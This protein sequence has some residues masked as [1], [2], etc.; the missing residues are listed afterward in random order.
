MTSN[1]V[2]QGVTAILASPISDSNLTS[3]VEDAQD[4][5]I[6]VFNVHDGLI[7]AAEY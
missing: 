7:A 2:N 5:G 1:M 6:P 4:Q 3:A